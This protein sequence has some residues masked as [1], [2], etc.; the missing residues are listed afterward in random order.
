MLEEASLTLLKAK[1]FQKLRA[2]E[3]LARAMQA[4]LD[5]DRKIQEAKEDIKD[6]PRYQVFHV[7]K[8]GN[9]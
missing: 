1:E 4:L 6:D 8:A 5:E 3:V 2:I 9:A 7:N